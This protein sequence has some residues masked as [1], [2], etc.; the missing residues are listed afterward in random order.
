MRTARRDPTLGRIPAAP[1][2]DELRSGRHSQGDKRRDGAVVGRGRARR[3][4]RD[5]RARGPVVHDRRGRD[6]RAHRAER[7]GQDDA[8][9]LRQPALPA[10]ERPHPLRRHATCSRCPRTASRGVGIAR[11]FQNLAL[12]PALTVAEN[13][14]VGAHARGG[15]TRTR[16]AEA[17]SRSSTGCRSSDLADRPAVGLPY[18]TLSASRSPARSRRGRGCCCSTS[19]RP[20]SR[21]P[22]STSSATSCASIRDEFELSVLLVE[23]HMAMVMAISEQIVVLDFGCKI[24]EGAAR[25]RSATTPRH[26][27][28]PR[29]RRRRD[30]AARGRGAARAAT[31]PVRVL[32]GLDFT[33]DEGEVVVILGANGAGKTTTLRALSGM[34]DAQGRVRFDGRVDPRAREPE[35]IAAR[36]HRA[37]PAGPGHDRR[38]HRRREPAARRVRAARPRGRRR[39]RALVRRV[40]AARATGAISRPGA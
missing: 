36:G 13:V 21:T 10:D 16:R 2:R 23:H 11:T 20:G 7:R 35:Q 27:G 15:S 8:L 34:I 26:R 17:R 40:P 3:V 29:E 5:R 30:R 9:Q 39:H 18:G 25:R 12:F 28:L 22:R 37:R 38:P 24:A 1:A 14:M 32:H 33:V 31:A 6:L 4:R 19:R